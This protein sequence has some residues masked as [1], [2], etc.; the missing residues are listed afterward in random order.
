MGGKRSQKNLMNV[1]L[2]EILELFI[3]PCLGWLLLNSN[4]VQ[5]RL[6]RI[7]TQLEDFLGECRRNRK[8]C[9]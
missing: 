3:V 7:E 2:K 4:K 9:K 8:D 1:D 6:T 5:R